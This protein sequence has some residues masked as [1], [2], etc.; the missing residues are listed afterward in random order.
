MLAY[1]GLKNGSKQRSTKN[2][3]NMSRPK[4][5][6][7]SGLRRGGPK[8]GPLLATSKTSVVDIP[9]CLKNASEKSIQNPFRAATSEK[10][11]FWGPPWPLWAPCWPLLGAMLAHLGGSVGAILG[12]VVTNGKVGASEST[13]GGSPQWLVARTPT[14]HRTG[15]RLGNRSPGLSPV[16]CR[17][18][19]TAPTRTQSAKT[20]QNASFGPKARKHRKTR[21]FAHPRNHPWRLSPAACR[22]PAEPRRAS[23]TPNAAWD[24]V[25]VAHGR[26]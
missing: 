6:L 25:S 9:T 23:K 26:L 15:R 10:S 1:V 4:N 20:L 13:P 18:H 12:H 22:A 16:A 3:P 5:A 11:R 19:T 2:V 21:G 24:R 8:N 17:A 7:A 14:L